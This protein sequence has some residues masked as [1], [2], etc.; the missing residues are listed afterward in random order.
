MLV[1]GD[2]LWGVL[3]LRPL[4][5]PRFGQGRIDLVFLPHEDDLDP[6]LAVCLHAAGHHLVGSKI[7]THG[8]ER[9]LHW[10][11]GMGAG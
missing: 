2:H 11:P 1:H 6:E 5:G 3:D 10:N 4:A 7:T 9:D 8:V